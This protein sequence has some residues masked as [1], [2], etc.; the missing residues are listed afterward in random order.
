M[1][2]SL[3]Q[4]PTRMER[5]LGCNAMQY[6]SSGNSLY[7]SR[8]LPRKKKSWPVNTVGKLL[9]EIS[10]AD[11]FVPKHD[12]DSSQWQHQYV[13]TSTVTSYARYDD[14]FCLLLSDI[15]WECVN[16]K[17]LQALTWSHSSRHAQSCP[18]GRWQMVWISRLTD[19]WCSQHGESETGTRSLYSPDKEVMV[20]WMS[21]I[22]FW[23]SI[24]Y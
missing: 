12:N 14:Y 7:S 3:S 17:T 21:E 24:V 1:R 15:D 5:P 8:D 20:K 6:R 18:L 10:T 2:Q 13:F 23:M 16:K 11:I 19:E 4:N 9:R 22:S